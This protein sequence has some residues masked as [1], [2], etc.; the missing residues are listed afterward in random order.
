MSLRD[1]D[2]ETRFTAGSVEAPRMQDADDADG[3]DADGGD[4]DAED[5]SDGDAA[6]RA[7]GTDADG[8]DA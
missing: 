3:T 1:D 5:A 2:I 4:G 8:T 6:D 7:D